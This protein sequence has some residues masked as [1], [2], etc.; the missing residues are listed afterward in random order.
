MEIKV[1]VSNRH[2]HLNREC[3]DLLFGKDYILNKRTISKFNYNIGKETT[4]YRFMV[5][6]SLLIYSFDVFTVPLGFS[7]PINF[8]T[9]FLFPSSDM[10]IFL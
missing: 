10:Y 3:I 7:I 8:I 5:V 6:A 4:Y 2:V 9:I 1:G